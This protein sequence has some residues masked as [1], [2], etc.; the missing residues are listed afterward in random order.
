MNALIVKEKK[1]FFLSCLK[2][3]ENEKIIIFKIRSER[4]NTARRLIK[5]LTADKI[6]SIAFEKDISYE[7][8]SFFKGKINIVEKEDVLFSNLDKIILKLAG[9]LG[10][11]EGKL[12]LGI[13]PGV[14]LNLAFKKTKELRGR[15]KSLFIF[16]ENPLEY[17]EYADEFYYNTGIPVILKN[18]SEKAN[19]DIL[20]YLDK[21][22][23]DKLNQKGKLIDIYEKVKSR[24]I[25]DVRISIPEEY[26]KYNISDCVLARI[27]NEPFKIDS[28]IT[29]KA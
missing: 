21:K 26:K 14:N 27:L 16:S 17:S 8:K 29:K 4:K 2:R 6:V 15:L 22:P 25:S 5:K 18:I 28:F 9:L 3:E 24:G 11:G 23:T 13:I 12:D 20:V 10:I 1:G 19:C 7:F